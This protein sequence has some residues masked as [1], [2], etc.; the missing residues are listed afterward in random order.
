MITEFFD[1]VKL[2]EATFTMKETNGEKETQSRKKCIR[3]ELAPE[4]QIWEHIGVFN[5]YVSPS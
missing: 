3:R 2:R 4:A 1:V 5:S